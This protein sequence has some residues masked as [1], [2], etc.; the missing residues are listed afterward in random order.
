[1]IG[2]PKSSPDRDRWGP[3]VAPRRF[4]AVT[5]CCTVALTLGCRGPGPGQGSGV[6]TDVQTASTPAV[7]PND[8]PPTRE[9]WNELPFVARP[10]TVHVVERGDTLFALARRYQTTV[11]TLRELNPGLDPARLRVGAPLILPGGKPAI[12]NVRKRVQAGNRVAARTSPSLRGE[13]GGW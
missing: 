7:F 5:A 2:S 9:P 3:P 10:I 4:V 1:M 8:P 11:P 6:L 13:S 12:R